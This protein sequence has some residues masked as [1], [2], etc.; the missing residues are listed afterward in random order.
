M[1]TR[2]VI[3]DCEEIRNLASKDPSERSLEKIFK[4]AGLCGARLLR[5]WSNGKKPL[6]S[7]LLALMN[8][9]H[10]CNDLAQ[11]TKK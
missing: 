8:Q 6:R 3:P 10:N 4:D 9:L 1:A 2:Y 7:T 11:I 5:D